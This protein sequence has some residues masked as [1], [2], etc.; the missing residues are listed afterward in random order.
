MEFI[1]AVD[2]N[3]KQEYLNDKPTATAQSDSFILRSADKYEAMIGKPVY[4]MT[5]AELREMLMMQFNNSSVKAINKNISILKVYVDFCINKNIVLHGENRLATFTIE[6]TKELVHK[7]ALIN[8]YVTKEKIKEYQNILYNDQD[9]L[10]L[11]SP[12]LG[13]RG[14]TTEDGTLEEIINLTIDDVDEIN[15]ELTLRQ[16]N[17]KKRKIEVENSIIELIKDTYKQE[18]YVENNGEETN[19]LRLS[20]PREIKINKL[21][22]FV[23]RVPSKNKFEQFTPNLLNSR[24]RRMQKYLDNPYLTYTSIFMSGILNMAMDIY[25]EKSEVSKEDFT[26]ICRKYN[27]GQDQPEKY[28]FNIKAL[29]EQY[30]ELLEN[31]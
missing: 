21:E 25:K 4:N 6:E 18:I 17:G 8:K 31:K 13:I 30:R 9:K 7:Q 19:N 22:N 12:F 24:M 29:F 5:Y 2:N 14:R 1:F 10:L 16:N 27:Y 20:K 23:F 15:N 28:W 26:R 3:I 11:E